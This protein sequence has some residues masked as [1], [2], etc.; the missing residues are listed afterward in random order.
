MST[1]HERYQKVWKQYQLE[2]GHCEATSKE[3][4]EWAVE[5]EYLIAQRINP[6]DDLASQ[7]S[8]AMRAEY[9]TDS[10]GR[11]YRANHARRALRNGEQTTI[12][13]TMEHASHEHMEV[14]YTQRRQQIVSDC[15]QLKTDVDVYNDHIPEKGNP[16][17][18]LDLDFTEDVA[19]REACIAGAA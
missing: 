11:R 17:I 12:W 8:Q 9:K 14:A 3:V 1:K 2:H 16:E 19:A 7:L 6:I 4:A 13:A 15:L 5:K 18:P 10:R